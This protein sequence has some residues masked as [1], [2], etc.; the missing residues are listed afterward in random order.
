MQ[1]ELK[2]YTQEGGTIFM[3]THTLP[4]A[5]E[6]ADRIGILERGRLLD[7][8]TLEEIRK[9]SKL[10][11]DASLEEIYLKLTEKQ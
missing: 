5:E 11:K 4:V 3:V 9:V 7:I 8:G 10:G 1:K 2:K 6:I